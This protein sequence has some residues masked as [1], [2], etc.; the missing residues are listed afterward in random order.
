MWKR[1]YR[2]C[3]LRLSIHYSLQLSARVLLLVLSRVNPLRSLSHHLDAV[4]RITEQHHVVRI[5]RIIQP[6]YDIKEASLAP[7]VVLN[8][9]GFLVGLA[10]LLASWRGW[11]SY[12]L[13]DLLHRGSIVGLALVLPS[14]GPAWRR[15]G[16]G[17]AFCRNVVVHAF[18]VIPQIPLAGKAIARSGA[19]ALLKCA[20]ERLQSMGMQSMGFTLVT[21]PAGSG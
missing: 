7:M 13:D 6:M 14:G 9:A 3:S 17:S 12:P 20:Q 8:Q 21:E 5:S 11:G 10:Q 4:M 18:H 1:V 2:I 16:A 15:R 19:L